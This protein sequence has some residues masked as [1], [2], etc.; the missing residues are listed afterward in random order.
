MVLLAWIFKGTGVHKWAPKSGRDNEGLGK[1]GHHQ[2]RPYLSL[3]GQLTPGEQVTP[4][5]TV[6]Q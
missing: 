4:A 1:Q 6:Q 3:W 5:T 2:A